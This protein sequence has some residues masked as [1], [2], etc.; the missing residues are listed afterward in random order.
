MNDLLLTNGTIYYRSVLISSFF[1][2]PQFNG[3]V[4]DIF[5]LA[6]WEIKNNFALM[7]QLSASI[8]TSAH[9]SESP[10]PYLTN[11][12]FEISGGYLDGL[13][14]MLTVAF[15]PL[16]KAVNQ[17][18]WEEYSVDNQ[19]W[20]EEGARLR[21][22]HP[23][24]RDPIDGTFQ[25]HEERRKLEQEL[26]G[27]EAKTPRIP[28]KIYSLDGNGEQIPYNASELGEIMA[29]VWQI[30]P[31]PGDDPKMVNFNLLADPVVADLFDVLVREKESVLS[32]AL[33]V[34]YLFDASFRPDNKILKKHPHS[35][36][37]EPVY[38]S[39]ETD[40]EMVGILLAL[41]SWE[42][43]F[44]NILP[45]GASGIVC[46]V[47]SSCGDEFSFNLVGPKPVF[48]GNGDIHDDTY[49]KY[50]KFLDNIEDYPEGT[51]GVCL[52]RLTVYPSSELRASYNTNRP[53]IYTSAIALAFVLTA[54]LFFLYDR[55][56]T[57]RQKMAS[58]DAARTSAFV[59]TLF[60]ANVRDRLFQDAEEEEKGRGKANTNLRPPPRNLRSF[61]M[62]GESRYGGFNEQEDSN[63]D[64][65]STETMPFKSKPIGK[66]WNKQLENSFALFSASNFRLTYLNT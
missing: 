43:L 13:S 4:S 14:G 41:T 61:M 3:Y 47:K 48:L 42:N 19:Y 52:H 10:F 39:F 15:A 29:P 44:N 35:Y 30:A 8:T 54:I 26:E 65:D 62:G 60:P 2:L 55:L 12:E 27:D 53:V 63:D 33:E 22:I 40:A 6:T 20:V 1:Q 25:D 66:C 56:V 58:A 24:H 51:E 50:G 21:V 18:Q 57:R 49:D 38:A 17:T 7:A 11:S 45:K 59:S 32:P 5:S 37:A 64:S 9:L 23:D 46:V 31:T 16:V 36:V 28:S 34:G